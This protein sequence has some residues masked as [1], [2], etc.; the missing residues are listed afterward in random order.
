[1]RKAKVAL[2]HR[3]IANAHR[4]ILNSN[5]DQA[6][7]YLNLA[8]TTV[9]EIKE[10]Q[11]QDATPRAPTQPRNELPPSGTG[12]GSASGEYRAKR[13]LASWYAET[14]GQ[15]VADGLIDGAIEYLKRATVLV[16]Q[17]K[18]LKVDR[19][20]DLHSTVYSSDDER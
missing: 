10:M 1:M 12:D 6:I 8:K 4:D 15:R 9:R 13:T 3:Y 2:A 19:L 5:E 16:R 20:D 17:M 7:T 14:A 11:P 18:T